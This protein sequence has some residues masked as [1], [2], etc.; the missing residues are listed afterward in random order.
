MRRIGLITAAGG[1]VFLHCGVEPLRANLIL[2]GSFELDAP[3]AGNVAPANWTLS[4]HRV[5]VSGGEGF[6]D[7]A[8]A[9]VFDNGTSGST[10]PSGTHSAELSQSFASTPGQTYTINVDYTTFGNGG[11][12]GLGV[13]AIGSGVL[14]DQ[15]FTRTATGATQGF[16][17]RYAYTFVA[18]SASTTISVRDAT[19]S[20]EIAAADGVADHVE[21]N[22]APKYGRAWN[23]DFDSGVTTTGTYIA[24]GAA[25][26]DGKTWNGVFLGNRNTP[27]PPNTHAVTQNNLLDSIGAASN[28]SITVSNINQYD[29]EPDGVSKV[30]HFATALMDDFAYVPGGSGDGSF[31]ISGLNK[32]GRYDL[33]LYAMNGAYSN[34]IT[35]FTIGSQTL[36]AMNDSLANPLLNFVQNNNYVFFSGLLADSSGVISGT[37][38]GGGGGATLNG[39]QIMEAPEPSSVLL[40]ALGAAGMAARRRRQ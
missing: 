27:A 7:G 2:N 36:T 28:V 5:I 16:I 18:N 15:T 10:P 9:A 26:I 35:S 37:F 30:S 33:Y 11:A 3:T 29:T 24:S 40:T 12:Q 17:N 6:S 22:T 4:G 8:L 21:V 39:F 20:G 32:N 34:A 13:K 19:T 14:L 1:F 38:N 23:V 25:P 31:V